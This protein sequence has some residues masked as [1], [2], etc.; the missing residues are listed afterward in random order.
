MAETILSSSLFTHAILPFLLVFTLI[1]AILQRSKILGEGKK[2]IDAI[3]ALVIAL[4][5]IAF[6]LPRSIIVFLMPFLA[7]MA[8]IILVFMLLWGFVASGKDG[9]VMNKG[10]KI[11][12]GII[13]GIALA[14]AIL[15]AAGVWDAVYGFFTGSEWS[16][17][18]LINILFI[19]I[20]IGAM[21]AVLAG[22]KSD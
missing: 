7:V 21:V 2:Q 3:V 1:F 11:T 22:N 20:I 18:I 13:I 8:V 16:Q 9:L 12:F 5:L 4:L 6:P 10:L 15:F 19:A 17:S 14:I